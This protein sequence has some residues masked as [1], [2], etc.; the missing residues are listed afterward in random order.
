MRIFFTQRAAKIVWVFAHERF[1]SG[2]ENLFLQ[3]WQNNPHFVVIANTW[4]FHG[5]TGTLQLVLTGLI[6]KIV[7]KRKR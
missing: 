1:I 4:K 6:P 5:I 2:V 3:K 7:C